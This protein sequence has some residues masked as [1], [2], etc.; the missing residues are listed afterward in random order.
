MLFLIIVVVVAL[1]IFWLIVWRGSTAFGI[2]LKPKMIIILS[3][4]MFGTMFVAMLLT[5]LSWSIVEYAWIILIWIIYVTWVLSPLLIVRDIVSIWYKI[6]VVFMIAI[7]VIWLG[8]GIY[9]WTTIK[10]TPLTISNKNISKDYKIVF[11]SDIH[12]EIIHNSRYVQKIVNKIK[13]IKPDFVLIG[14]DL[15]NSA[16]LSYV[17]AFLPFNQIQV[18]VYATLW[19]HDHM[20]D[21]GVVAKIS[22]KTNIVVLRNQSID[23]NGIQVVGIDD[24]SYRG[25]KKI[26]DILKESNISNSGQFTILVSHQ[27]QKLNKLSLYQIDLELAWH[28][29]N[30]QFIPFSRII[31]WLN[32][33]KYGKYIYNDMIAFVSQWIG[34][35]WAPIRIW[36]QSELVLV[37]LSPITK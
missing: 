9:K 30:G 13:E 28:T 12:V 8:F 31:W 21:S 11:I 26:T 32:D 35:W 33:Y 10:V 19:N 15:M 34:S 7:S 36:T 4:A 29:H 18:A 22:E 5:N 2:Y 23:V 37:S 25:N 16:K 27:P 24:K 17:D 20:G 1:G 6:P 3:M 14:W